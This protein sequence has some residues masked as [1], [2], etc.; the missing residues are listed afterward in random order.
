MIE[1]RILGGLIALSIAAL[2]RILA[3]L[4]YGGPAS[5]EDQLPLSH[6]LHHV[7]ILATKMPFCTLHIQTFSD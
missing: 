3:V 2:G 5:I 4:S 7:C 6:H 1:L